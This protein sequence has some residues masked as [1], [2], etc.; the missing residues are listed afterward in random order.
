MRRRW[1]DSVGV[2][3][4]PGA[5]VPVRVA[6]SERARAG[7]WWGQAGGGAEVDLDVGGGAAVGGG[8]GEGEDA[9][10]AAVEGR[11]G[12]LYVGR[13]RHLRVRGR[14][15][16]AGDV[17]GRDRELAVRTPARAMERRSRPALP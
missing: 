1:R 8:L 11:G 12:G 5:V 2:L 4:A 16:R 13:C 14:A 9:G 17:V 7:G 3:R 15:G 10:P 6:A